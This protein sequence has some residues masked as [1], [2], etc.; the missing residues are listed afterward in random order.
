MPRTVLDGQKCNS[1]L[2]LDE[3][4]ARG[5]CLLGEMVFEEGKMAVPATTVVFAYKDGGKPVHH[6]L[7]VIG[8]GGEMVGE[9]SGTLCVSSE[10]AL[11]EGVDHSCGCCGEA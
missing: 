3:C 6:E 7:Q 8:Y 10:E 1:T 5:A 4:V 2:N 11:E 9:T